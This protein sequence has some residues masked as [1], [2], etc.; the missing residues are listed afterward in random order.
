MHNLIFGFQRTHL[1]ENSSFRFLVDNLFVVAG[2][3]IYFSFI[4]KSRLFFS[5]FELFSSE[6][7]LVSPGL[8][9]ALLAKWADNNR[10]R[11]KI[12]QFFSFF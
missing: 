2:F 5:P 10:P 4:R 3:G 8:M 11:L 9:P 12:K 1:V 6:L 7:S